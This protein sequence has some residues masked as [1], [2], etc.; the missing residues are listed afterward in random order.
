MGKNWCYFCETVFF[1]CLDKIKKLKESP[2]MDIDYFWVE[3]NYLL[4][5]LKQDTVKINNS[6]QLRVA[7]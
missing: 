7:N 6:L 3:E 4:V 1:Y 2:K 5:I